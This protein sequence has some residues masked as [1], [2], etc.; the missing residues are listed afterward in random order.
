M[1]D[2]AATDKD[3]LATVK[4]VFINR[5]GELRCGWRILLF[6]FA[7]QILFWLIGG[8]VAIL[9]ILIPAI[10]K[11]LHPQGEVGTMYLGS[12]ILTQMVSLLAVLGA[13]ALGARFLEHRSFASTGYK[14]HKYWWRDFA[15]GLLLGGITLTV[16]VGLAALFGATT[17]SVNT[18]DLQVLLPSFILLFFCFLI[19]AA[20]EEAL[21]R[22]FAFQAL[23]HNLGKVVALAVTALVF[24]LLHLGNDYVTLFS[25]INT[26]IAGIWLGVAYLMTRSLWLAT[27]L[28]FAWNFTMVFIFGLPVSGF[29]DFGKYTW[30]HG[31]ATKTWISGGSY[32]PEGGIA[33]TAA[34]LLCTLAIWKSGIFSTTAEM[35]QAIQHGRPQKAPLSILATDQNENSDS[36]VEESRYTD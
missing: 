22:G 14:F 9:G 32:G 4:Y 36:R 19:A 25:T 21:V 13:N 10:R 17:F 7:Y 1:T 8:S 15:F 18:N 16:A 33:A 2:R 24:G 30:L 35:A 27:A 11:L 31:E 6:I 5:E 28:H 20:N 29:N 26:M 12:F 3:F 23:T 34:L